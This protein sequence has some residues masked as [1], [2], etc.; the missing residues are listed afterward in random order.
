MSIHD[1]K[2][3][4]HFSRQHQCGLILRTAHEAMFSPED[5]QVFVETYGVPILGVLEDFS[6]SRPLRTWRQFQ[7]FKKII[8]HFEPDIVHILFAEPNALWSFCRGATK[9]PRWLLTTRGTD[10]LVTI[11]RF[12]RRADLLA[13]LVHF[14]YCR[15]FARFDWVVGTS[16]AQL[17][18]VRSELGF[19]G[20]C[21]V[22]RTGSD[23]EAVRQPRP[24]L[25]PAGLRNRPY[26]FFPRLMTPLYDQELSLDVIAALPPELRRHYSMVFVDCDKGEP[27]YVQRIRE[28]MASLPEVDFH[29]LKREEPAVVWELYKAAQLTVMTPCSDGSPVSAMESL[30]CGTPVVAPPLAYDWELKENLLVADSWEVS[31]FVRQIE[32]GLGKRVELALDSP[33]YQLCDRAL[34]MRLMEQVYQA[35]SGSGILP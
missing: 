10:I 12:R 2:W 34:Q 25:L 3:M 18:V 14:L 13:R 24:E 30:L 22:V 26:I 1:V 8:D 27:G 19:D 23:V 6:L 29:F 28:K 35:N 15:A 5:R 32:C 9:T 20:P 4:G 11:P 31:A 21:S 16:N 17:D 33:C 7:S